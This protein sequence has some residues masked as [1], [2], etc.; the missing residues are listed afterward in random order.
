VHNLTRKD[1]Q[2]IND[3]RY[4]SLT[5]KS[6]RNKLGSQFGC[7]LQKTKCL[8]I[9]NSPQKTME[10]I[11]KFKQ[12]KQSYH[13]RNLLFLYLEH[14]FKKVGY[15]IQ[16]FYKTS[17]HEYMSPAKPAMTLQCLKIKKFQ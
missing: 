15:K 3:K 10:K 11:D 17:F 14:N 9:G 13:K 12:R 8:S 1:L 4:F 2:K 16:P 6:S 7:S 5:S